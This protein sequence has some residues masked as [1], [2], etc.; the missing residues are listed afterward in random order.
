MSATTISEN[1][2]ELLEAA[3][4]LADHL[5]SIDLPAAADAAALVSAAVP[6]A[7]RVVLAA[8]VLPDA[9]MRALAGGGGQVFVA[10][11]D[12]ENAEGLR[13]RA[14]DAAIS[15]ATLHRTLRELP[16]RPTLAIVAARD[17]AEIDAA[18][19]PLAGCMAAGTTAIVVGADAAA[20][21]S[22]RYAG[23]WRVVRSVGNAVALRLDQGGAG[24][25]PAAWPAEQFS[26]VRE[27]LAQSRDDG[28]GDATTTRTPV[29]R[30]APG[31]GAR[32]G[33]G[34]LAAAL[35]LARVEID[36]RPQRRLLEGLGR[37]PWVTPDAAPLPSTMPDGSP[38]P[39]ITIV[40]P[41]YNQGH[42]IEETIL[43]I[44]RQGYPNLEHILMDGASTDD[45]MRVAERYRDHF[46]VAVSEKDKGQSDALNKGFERATGE[47]LT[48]INSDDMLAPGA[49][50]AAAIA[51]RTSGADFLNG[52]AQV[53]KDGKLSHQCITSCAD[54]PMPL[55]DM[56]DLENCWLTGQFWWQP[57]C[58]FT[59]DLW[60]RAGAHVRVDWYYSMDYEL[61]LRFAEAGARVHSIGRPIVW[62][63]THDDQKTS[64]DGGGGFKGELPKVVAD[65]CETRK[66]EPEPREKETPKKRLRVLLLNDVGFEYGA[67]IGQRRVGQAFAS[68]GHH[69]D[70]LSATITE[71]YREST[72]IAVADVLEAVAAKKPD[73]VVVGNVHG[74]GITAEALS[75]VAARHE[76]VF[77]MHDQWLLT[78][79][80][81]YVGDATDHLH[82]G[83]SREALGASYPVMPADRI[84]PTWEAQR[85]FL[86]GSDR[87][88]VLTN[89][90]WMARCAEDALAA[91]MADA[92][93]GTPVDLGH[94]PPVRPITL[95][96][97]AQVFR[98]RDRATCRDLLGL[99]PDDFIVMASACSLD[100]ER[101]GIALLADAMRQLDL[102]D[103]TVVGVGYVPPK[104]EL[105]IPGMRAMGYMRDAQRLAMLYSAAD[106]FVAPSTDEAFGQVFI[107][108]AACGTPSV[109]FPVGG[110]PEAIRDGVTGVVAR[111]VGA[112]ALAEAIELL[113]RDEAYRRDLG[114]WARI[115]AENEFSLFASYQRIHTA[116]ASSGA[117]SRIGLSRKIDFTRPAPMPDQPALI[118][119]TLPAYEPRWGFE[120]WQP[121]MPEK[122]LGRH[123]WI[124]GGSAGAI[125]HASKPGPAKLALT[126]RN[127]LKGQRLRVVVNGKPAGEMAVPVTGELAD[128]AITL[129]VRLKKGANDVQLHL[130]KW[131][132]AGPRPLSLLLTDFTLI[133]D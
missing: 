99:P 35:D 79:K 64:E 118:R 76:T 44:Q 16:V 48:W 36:P 62:F 18:L 34:E 69:V 68:A 95:G 86:T 114:R 131:K 78:G 125:M 96:L 24:V 87:L 105:P 116:L 93:D 28:S 27:R 63:R 102:P 7:G 41:S 23:A 11:G 22:S 89:S 94:R 47:L 33:D 109:G 21:R 111:E 56:L 132:L 101:K 25:E 70:A 55:R 88:T 120:Y 40:T 98:P 115:H 126:C 6:T 65:F 57:D 121:A 127:H 19:G 29:V 53:F 58:F 104:A 129:P 42:F 45:T 106:V 124:K 82:G 3:R 4:R 46:A 20:L 15:K 75:A 31:V 26:A 51:Y 1:Q 59:R 37:W 52:M 108:A 84:R 2:G 107:E 117:G 90:R 66:M 133:E 49:L 72:E 103:A 50:A 92:E 17:V 30:P 97:D 5:A 14:P 12:A 9:I 83:V 100:D 38:W 10:A 61:W 80:Q 39:R 67:G 13:P 60:E 130:W 85:R 54:G 73:L 128:H 71:P 81:T 91:P 77:L 32:A 110:V 119:P 113:H 122:N 74:S 123:R 112:G 43:S 8:G